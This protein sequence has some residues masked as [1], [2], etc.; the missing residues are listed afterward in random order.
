M[1]AMGTRP[2]RSIEPQ[3][4]G[5]GQTTLCSR[6]VISEWASQA[7][8]IHS[9]GVSMATRV[10]IACPPIAPPRVHALLAQQLTSSFPPPSPLQ[11]V[12]LMNQLLVGIRV[13][14]MYAWEAAQ[15][16][17]VRWAGVN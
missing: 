9:V 13:L 7:E 8:G 12:K 5:C 4:L 14:K 1:L 17:A 10:C 15:E 11:R 16:A 6:E 2:V 3:A